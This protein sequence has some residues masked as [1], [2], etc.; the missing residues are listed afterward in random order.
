MTLYADNQRDHFRRFLMNM[1]GDVEGGLMP[2]RSQAV[3]CTYRG[4]G[5]C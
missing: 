5:H 2:T 3:S 4:I 1:N